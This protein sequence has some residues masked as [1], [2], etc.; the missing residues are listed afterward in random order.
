MK[1]RIKTVVK[2]IVAVIVF[3]LVSFLG[4]ELLA[5]VLVN[6][7]LD[8]EGIRTAFS[9]GSSLVTICIAFPAFVGI[10]ALLKMKT[11][12][13]FSGTGRL[14]GKDAAIRILLAMLPMLILYGVLLVKGL[15]G[16]DVLAFVA[17]NPKDLPQSILIS[18]LLMPVV[19]EYM[20]RGIVLQNMKPYGKWLAIILST[21]CD[22]AWKSGQYSVIACSRAG[23]CGNGM[24]NRGN[25]IWNLFPYSGKLFWTDY[26]P[27]GSYRHLLNTFRTC[28]L[29]ME[30]Y[31]DT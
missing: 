3:Q 9:W 12:G 18:C 11:K 31:G 13:M 28:V 25:T 30:L 20:F 24:E 21:V 19:E 10:S 29:R 27:D 8:S 1:G 26:I 4:T 23:V 22:R 15:N 14:S 2:V 5:L 7:S 16:E 6:T 17:W